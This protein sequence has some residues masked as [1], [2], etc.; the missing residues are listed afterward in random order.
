MH[1][2]ARSVVTIALLGVPAATLVYRAA[3]QSASTPPVVARTMI[4]ATKLLVV[5]GEP[6]HFKVVAVMLPAEQSSSFHGAAGFIYQVS[7]STEVSVDGTTKTLG[8]AEGSFVS[9]TIPA[10]LR[11]AGGEPST[12]LHFLLAPGAALDQ[13]AETAPAVVKELYRTAAP[14]PDLKAGVYDLNLSRITFPPQMPPNKPHYRSGGALYYVLSGTG[15]NTVGGNT[16]ARP[17]GSLIYE[18][19]GLV[20]QW[21]N[22]GDTPFTFL[23]F[24]IN[25]DDTA[26]VLP[27][28]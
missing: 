12:F 6:L 11:A 4:A 1:R 24:N 21:G 10:M 28:N 9:G 2:L 16:E 23:V 14:I 8:A 19:F 27:A 7:G 13:P 17:P 15:S 20:H 26:A 3:A 22:P 25:P 5:V 18:P